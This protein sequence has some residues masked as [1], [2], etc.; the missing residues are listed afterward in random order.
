MKAA[1]FSGGMVTVMMV[2]FSGLMTPKPKPISIL[3]KKRIQKLSIKKG[4]TPRKPISRRLISS[5]RL[6][7]RCRVSRPTSRDPSISVR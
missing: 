3:V 7:L 1:L 4:S 2:L 5:S 6:T